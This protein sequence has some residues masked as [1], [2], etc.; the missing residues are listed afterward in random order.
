MRCFLGD[1]ACARLQSVYLS[2][3]I[4]FLP[5][6][7][8]LRMQHNLHKIS[9]VMFIYKKKKRLFRQNMIILHF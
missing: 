2:F 8:R 4:K 5:S 3:V 7:F 1:G 6:N 9:S